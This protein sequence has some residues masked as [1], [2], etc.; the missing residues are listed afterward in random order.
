MFE[1]KTEED[2]EVKAV[3]FILGAQQ[4]NSRT[5]LNRHRTTLLDTAARSFSGAQIDSPIAWSQGST[6]MGK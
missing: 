3:F 5:D 2:D 4:D 1:H 6:K